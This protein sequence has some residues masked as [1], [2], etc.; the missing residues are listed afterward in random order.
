MI[1][2]MSGTTRETSSPISVFVPSVTV[3]GRSVFERSVRQ[4]TPSTLVSSWMPPESV[5][6][7]DS[8]GIQEETS[9]LGVPCLT[10][11]SNTERP[12]TVTLGTNTLIGDDVS[13][14]VPLIDEIIGGRYKSG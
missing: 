4:G 1:S 5:T 10:L 14:V 6:V 13:R 8:G 7:T 2:S 11:R 12:V 9:V 3:T